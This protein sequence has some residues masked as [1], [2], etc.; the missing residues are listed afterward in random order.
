MRSCAQ[1]DV[2]NKQ[3]ASS[4]KL[5]K[6]QAAS[7]KPRSVR[8]KLQATSHKLRDPGT[9]EHINK[10]RGPRTECLGYDESVL[11]MCLMECNLVCRKFKFVPSGNF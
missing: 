10:F 6:L 7:F 1:R 5:C 8:P 11:W 3:Q 4:A 2:S 9:T